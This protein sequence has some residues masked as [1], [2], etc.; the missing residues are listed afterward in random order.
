MKR[1]FYVLAAL[2]VA[3]TGCNKSI[4]EDNLL[5]PLQQSLDAKLVG[6]NNGEIVPGTLLV[7]LDA[8][9]ICLMKQTLKYLI[10]KHLTD[11]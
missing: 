2:A 3:G 8:Y 11:N 7:R 6:E 5:T 1:L 9:I 10:I 4:Q